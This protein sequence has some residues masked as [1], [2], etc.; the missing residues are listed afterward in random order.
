MVL[1]KRL[2]EMAKNTTPIKLEPGH[3]RQAGLDQLQVFL[4]QLAVDPRLDTEH[5]L[6]SLAGRLHGLWRKLRDTGDVGHL[7]RNHDCGAASSTI[8][9]SLPIATLPTTVSGRKKVM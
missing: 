9:T 1:R 2:S 7:R 4:Q 8:C 6:L 5:Q 3:A